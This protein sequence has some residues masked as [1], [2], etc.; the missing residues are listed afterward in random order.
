MKKMTAILMTA[1]FLALP[2]TMSVAQAETAKVEKKATHDIIKGVV[3]SLDAT[4]GEVVIKDEASATDKTVTGVKKEELAEL[5]VGD[6]VKA[7]V[8]AGTAEAVSVA[9]MKKSHKS[10]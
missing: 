2:L 10:K 9:K 1:A 5:K 6:R 8:N 4:K 3:V 7:K